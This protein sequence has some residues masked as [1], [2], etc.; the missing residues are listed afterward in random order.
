[1]TVLPHHDLREARD[2]TLELIG[3]NHAQRRLLANATPERDS[4]L[5][6]LQHWR[7]KYRISDEDWLAC[8]LPLG[9]AIALNDQEYVGERQIA[10]TLDDLASVAHRHQSRP[11]SFKHLA[12]ALR[13]ALLVMDAPAGRSA[14]ALIAARRTV[15]DIVAI[16]P[17]DRLRSDTLR[18]ELRP[19]AHDVLLALLDG[20]S[21]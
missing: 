5:D 20:A 15:T 8:G 12:D 11:M 1:M 21:A 9:R 3:L 17:S 4:V 18:H 6:H 16:T 19:T 7:T 10:R 13:E 2:E 14:D